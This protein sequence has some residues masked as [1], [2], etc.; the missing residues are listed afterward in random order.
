MND[1]FSITPGDL[2]VVVGRVVSTTT[3]HRL[4]PDFDDLFFVIASWHE[5]PKKG[6]KSLDFALLLLHLKTA[7]LVKNVKERAYGFKWRIA[8][9]S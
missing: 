9:F 8:Q 6:V 2:F 7:A 5:T 1:V 3:K 4:A